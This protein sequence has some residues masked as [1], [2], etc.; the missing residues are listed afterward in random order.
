MV[1]RTTAPDFIEPR[2]F[3][4]PQPEVIRFDN[5]SRFF[6][7]NVGDQPVI[8]LEFIFKAGSWF[9][10]LPGI[11][12]FTGKMLVE[13]TASLSSN[14]IAENLDKFGAFVEIHSGLDYINLSI[15]IPS[16]H[17]N[18]LG[19]TLSEILFNPTFPEDELNLLKQIQVQQI[20]VNEHKNSFVASRLFRSSLYG[21]V[22]YGHVMTEETINKIAS[23]DLRKHFERYINGKFDIFLTGK[24]DDSLPESIQKLVGQKLK[25]VKPFHVIPISSQE[26]FNHNNE[27]KDSLQS[28]IFIGK[29]C[30]N[31]QD[32]SFPGLLLLNEIFGGYFGSRL[33]QN[34]REDKGYTY[35]IYSH[36][37]TMKND[38]YFFI[39]SEVRKEI[40]DLAIEEIN[41]EI[42]KLKN[43]P[44]GTE[45][46]YQAKNYLK[47]SILN[48]LTSPFAITEKLKNI[49]L[50]DLEEFFYDQ[51]FNGIDDTND[52]EL[53][54]LANN[55]LFDQPLSSVVVG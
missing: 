6:Y 54:A 35:S 30:L 34:I 19:S 45:E 31:K 13:G 7:L 25:K 51:L 41:K 14:T 55:M 42:E 18:A 9:E 15:H 21:N 17:F 4:L 33:M 38:A 52:K 47:G 44:V 53:L 22:P 10:S 20:K 2:K 39:N 23:E 1:D 40:K 29:R 8:K 16:R 46:L 48:T 26:Y 5:G 49:Y 36:L 12:H 28:S 27:K 50:Y 32:I 3:T 43:F 37:A 24:F 11:A